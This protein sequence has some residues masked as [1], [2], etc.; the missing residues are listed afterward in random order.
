MINE[1]ISEK[2]LRSLSLLASLCIFPFALLRWY[3][4]EI[5]LAIIDGIISVTLFSFFIYVFI[6]HKTDVVKGL[7]AI[8]IAIAS[9][10]SIAIKGQSHILWVC[11]VIIAVH[12]LIPIKLAGILNLMLI[13]IM[14]T[15]IYPVVSSV[16]LITTIFTTGLMAILSLVIFRSYNNKQDELSLLATIDPLTMAGNRRALDNKLENALA[17][18]LRGQYPMCLILL[19]LDYFKEIN[20][21]HGHAVGDQILIDVSKLV[22]THTRALDCLYRYGGDE[23]IIM[24]LSMTL[25]KAKHLAENIR[26][27]IENY[28]F[29]N[30][31]S[32]TLSIGVSQYMINDTPQ[33]WISRADIA[34]YK[35]KNNG[36][37]KVY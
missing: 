13:S 35:A 10:S 20:D 23:F 3:N 14:L 1:L 33:S 29:I 25:N 2:V 27:T 9:L 15:I 18:Q 21:E 22:N 11:P 5:T 6:T 37:N 36:R 17:S 7:I 31:I 12:Y 16:D 24:P 32:L 8:F 34:L 30:D 26:S 4:G 28:Q 19:D